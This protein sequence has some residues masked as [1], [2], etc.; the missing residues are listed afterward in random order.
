MIM[1][2][3]L[4]S[5]PNTIFG[6]RVS[7]CFSSGVKRSDAKALII[8]EYNNKRIAIYFLN[9][10]YRNYLKWCVERLYIKLFREEWGLGL[11]TYFFT[12]LFLSV[13]FLLADYFPL[14]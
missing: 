14:F 3:Q 2:A 6:C 10:T 7:H 8:K 13:H 9:L 1:G 4:F 11:F 12:F 5:M